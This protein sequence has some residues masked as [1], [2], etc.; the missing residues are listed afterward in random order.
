MY[1]LDDVNGYDCND[2]SNHD[3]PVG[4]VRNHLPLWRIMTDPQRMRRLPVSPVDHVIGGHL[5]PSGNIDYGWS[6]AA[7]EDPNGDGDPSSCRC[8]WSPT[9][10]LLVPLPYQHRSCCI[11]TRR[12]HHHPSARGRDGRRRGLWM[13]MA[14]ALTVPLKSTSW[15]S[16]ATLTMPPGPDGITS[17]SP[18]RY[19][20]AG[21]TG[22]DC[23]VSLYN[24]LHFG[25][26]AHVH[27]HRCDNEDKG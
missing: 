6:A 21:S 7:R 15:R 8:A 26:N 20:L 18:P 4:V 5:L 24:A 22:R 16:I 11:G 10:A 3:C 13:T 12:V 14:M 17:S 23:L 27:H 9:H 25:S 2:G 19:L 1:F